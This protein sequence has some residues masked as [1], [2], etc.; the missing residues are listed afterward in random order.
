MGGGMND[1]PRNWKRLGVL[2]WIVWAL[3]FVV[4]EWNGLRSGTDG[5]PPLTGVVHYGVAAPITFIGLGWVF[6]HFVQ[7][8]RSG[9]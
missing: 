6:W 3:T 2:V 4:L 1:N 9:K 7:T 5:W 8:Y